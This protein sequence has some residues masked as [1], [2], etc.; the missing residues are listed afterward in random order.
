MKMKQISDS[1]LKITISLNDLE[2]RGMELADFL[3][4]QEKTEDFFHSV[5]EELDLPDH[6]RMSGMLSFRVTP[7]QDRV[8]IFVTKSEVAT[9]FNM[10]DMYDLDE[11]GQ[12]SHEELLDHM[13]R[14]FEEKG[15]QTAL[16]R[17][18]EAE[19]SDE[20]QQQEEAPQEEP[21][22]YVHYVLTFDKL[23]EVVTYAK[24]VRYEVA[25]S[26]LYKYEGGYQLTVLIYV[27]DKPRTYPSQI[28]ARI[29]EHAQESRHTR[30]H[31]REHAI[32]LREGD[33]LAELAGLRG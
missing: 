23:E 6:F 9:D 21:L 7:K 19:R 22:D 17:L 33:I 5:L 16:Q 10:T 18:E 25:A 8:D 24:T 15:D 2:E 31:L 1:T 26:E 3:I 14:F 12:L 20:A 28:Y 11:M 30:A 32:L 13:G 4:P 29:L 27:A